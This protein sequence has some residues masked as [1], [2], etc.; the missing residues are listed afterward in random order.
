MPVN[1]SIVSVSSIA[2]PEI[3]VTAPTPSGPGVNSGNN[4]QNVIQPIQGATGGELLVYPS[5]RP[6]YY[7]QFDIYNYKRASLQSVGTLGNAI[8][9]IVLPLSANLSDA[10]S[11][12]FG[13]TPLGIGGFAYDQAGIALSGININ[14]LHNIGEL[15]DA[16]ARASTAAGL[17][18]AGAAVN[19]SAAVANFLGLG[20]I[21]DAGKAFLGFA[22]NQFMTVLFVGPEYKQ[23]ELVW[24]L[25]PNSKD[26]AVT[27]RKIANTFKNAMS[28]KAA[29]NGAIWL[30][31][32]IFWPSFHPNSRFLYKFKPCVLKRFIADYAPTG[33]ASFF[34]DT[35]P[36][37]LDGENAPEGMVFRALFQEIE[38][39]QDGDFNDT[40]S[41]E[42]VYTGRT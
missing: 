33:R 21:L 3:V 37:P 41:P 17:G 6:K 32:K 29:L 35:D 8:S 26:E 24:A 19:S 28:G 5:D 38:L 15:S 18:V 23:F 13:D 14:S 30:H 1:T 20:G 16:M 36:N 2:L 40:N 42:N 31:P 25:S 12:K 9:T 7:L 4:P 34:K 39:W 22:P 11:V 27:L 10:N